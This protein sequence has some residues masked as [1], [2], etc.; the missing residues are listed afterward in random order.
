MAMAAATIWRWR[1]RRQQQQPGLLMAT[2]L[3]KHRKTLSLSVLLLCGFFSLLFA[4]EMS[5]TFQATYFKLHIYSL[6]RC[7]YTSIFTHSRS[8]YSHYCM[9]SRILIRGQSV[10]ALMCNTTFNRPSDRYTV[11]AICYSWTLD[12]MV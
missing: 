6:S 7:Q 8:Y 5:S 10:F 9:H 4:K 12:G 2:M 11:N 3:H 1:R